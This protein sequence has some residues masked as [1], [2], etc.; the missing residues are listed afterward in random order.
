[1]IAPLLAFAL[2]CAQ[3]TPPPKAPEVTPFTVALEG[4]RKALAAKD[5]EKARAQLDRALE[6]D[7]RSVKAWDLRARLAEANGDRDEQVFSLHREH[8]LLVAQKAPKSEQ[9]AVRGKLIGLDPIAPEL[10]D[11][12]K[13]FIAKL[14]P[15]AQQYEKDKRPHSA[16]R[17][18]KA[19]LALDPELETS[20]AAIERIAAAPDP[21]LAADAKPK[22]LLADV[23][24]E[25]IASTTSNT[26]DW[27]TRAKLERENYTTYTDA[28]YEVLV[29][30][31]EAMEQMNAFYRASSSTA[32]RRTAEVPRIDLA[33]LQEPR[34]VPEARQG[35]SGRVV[36]RPLHRRQRSRPTSTAA[37]TA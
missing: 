6:R 30:A 5:L 29:R 8:K 28:G 35:P 17:V 15:I 25:W 4:A 19:M 27:D 21:S 9:D 33:H 16:I 12:S 36:G 13:V 37:S 22:D 24:R 20:R 10:L 3:A 32:R 34:R 23:S 31:A 2:F 18:H 11:L 26:L 7:P 14:A 1:M